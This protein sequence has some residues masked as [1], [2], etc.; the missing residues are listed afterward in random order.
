V[1]FVTKLE[2]ILNI[3]YTGC[4]IFSTCIVDK[5]LKEQVTSQN[6]GTRFL[7]FRP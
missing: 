4:Q 6:E 7:T 5:E 2:K 3:E 1:F